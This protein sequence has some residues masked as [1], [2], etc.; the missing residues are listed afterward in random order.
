MDI[1]CSINITLSYVVFSTA[2]KHTHTY[3]QLAFAFS[4]YADVTAEWA[5]THTQC[6]HAHNTL[7]YTIPHT[8]TLHTHIHLHTHTHTTLHYSHLQDYFHLGWH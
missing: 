7:H 4:V 2:H 5:A 8:H 1:L 3:G 6:T